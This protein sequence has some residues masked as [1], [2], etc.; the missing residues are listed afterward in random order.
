MDTYKSNL[1]SLKNISLNA[2]QNEAYKQLGYRYH[3]S[4][5]AQLDRGTALLSDTRTMWQYMATY[6]PMHQVKLLKAFKYVPP[7]FFKKPF[8]IVDWG[9]GQAIGTITLFDYL[10]SQGIPNLIKKVT[11]IDPSE[12][13]LELAKFHTSLYVEE[14]IPIET[15]ASFFEA[16]NPSDITPQDQ[17]ATLHI[18][19]N[20]IDI[21]EI[22]LKKLANLLDQSTKLES[23]V[24]CVSPLTPTNNRLHHF[25]RYFNRPLIHAESI[26][27]LPYKKLSGNP[28]ICTYL[29]IIFNL[30]GDTTENLYPIY[31]YP[32]VYFS[33]AASLGFW[34]ESGLGYFDLSEF[35]NYKV[36]SPFDIGAHAYDD[37]HPIL[38]VLNN[39][40]MRGLPTKTS[41]YIEEILSSAF[42]ATVKDIVR[43]SIYYKLNPNLSK[44]LIDN[45]S[46]DLFIEVLDK[47][48][49]NDYNDYQLIWL[50]LFLT[51][52][53]INRFQKVL[54]ESIIT[55]RLDLN[56]SEWHIL[57][58]EQDV[59][60]AAL[61]VNDF[62]EM[63]NNLTS[64]TLDY[65]DLNLPAIYLDIISNETFANSPLHIDYEVNAHPAQKHSIREYDMVYDGSML[66]DFKVDRHTFSKYKAKSDCYFK[67][68]S[69]KEQAKN[70]LIYTSDIIKYKSF[71][72]KN[73]RG[74]YNIN[75][76]LKVKLQYFL[77]LL[78]RKD[79][80]REGQLPILDR[81]M[82]FKPVIGLLPTGGGK[83]LTY[84][85]AAM[86]Q[87][88]VSIVIDPLKSLMKDQYEGLLQ[89]G[90]DTANFI[91]SSQSSEERKSVENRL[92][93]SELQI[94]FI[95]PERLAIESFRQSLR[96][97]HS[98]NV[99]FAYGVIDE[100]HCVSEWGHDFRFNYLHL[101]RNLYNYVKSKQ[102]SLCL[103]GLTAT[104]SFDV[105]A[106]VERE[107]SGKGAFQLD[108]D[109]VIRFE[110]TNRLELQYKIEEV[111][112]K[113]PED[114]YFDRNKNL[115]LHLPRP[116]NVSDKWHV[117]NVKGEYVKLLIK[118]VPLLFKDLNN[119]IAIK[120]I[121]DKF[122]ARIGDKHQ[123]TRDLS[124][125]VSNKLLASR[126]TYDAAGIVFCP[127]VTGTGI[128][129]SEIKRKLITVNPDVGS[130]TGRDSDES[131]FKNMDKFRGNKQAIM[132]ATK[133]FG[134]GIDKP[135]VRFTI[136]TNYSSS[137]EGFIQEAGR[138]GRDQ[139]MAIAFLLYANYKI[140]RIKPDFQ[141][142]QYPLMLIKNKWFQGDD[143]KKYIREYRLKIPSD[144]IE[145]VTPEHDMVKLKCN[146]NNRMFA[147]NNC[148]ETCKAY[149]NCKLKNTP[150]DLKG[151]H[152]ELD[153]KRKLKEIGLN[154]LSKDFTYMSPDFDTVLYFFDENFKGDAYELSNLE[155]L[156]FKSKLTIRFVQDKRIVES[157]E[158]N[159]F[160]QALLSDS[161]PD[162]IHVIVPYTEE[163]Y[164]DIAKAIYRM[165]CI[166][167]VSDFTQDY[168]NKTLKIQANKKAHGSYYDE[169]KHFLLRYYSDEKANEEVN[170]AKQQNTS[171]HNNP[172]VREIYNCLSY[173]TFF[174]YSKISE[175]RKRAILDM[176]TFCLNGIE[177]G[178]HW[179]Q[180]NEELKDYL[181]Y[182]FNS[183]YARS[184]Y[185]TEVGGLP[186]SLVDDTDYGKKSSIALIKK[187]LRVAN[188][189]AIIG[190]STP[191]DN[192]R[193]LQGASKYLLRSVTDTN[194]TVSLLW[195]FSTIFLGT[196][197]NTRLLNE[198]RSTLYDGMIALGNDTG[199]NDSFWEFFTYFTNVIDTYSHKHSSDLIR[200]L[201]VVVHGEI[202]SS[203]TKKYCINGK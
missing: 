99:Y 149:H 180:T 131:S 22:D 54:L 203:I 27:E 51:P 89:V 93:S 49:I 23:I 157:K 167:L 107:L 101:G 166:D 120:F 106:D 170:Y 122:A 142:N 102:G 32:P 83:S 42:N 30:D 133:A 184:G 135:N 125:E 188:D 52:L 126:K 147:F 197:D 139:R 185:K 137:L 195:A 176:R 198:L 16:L 73:D 88:G 91:N 97:M 183:K 193:H 164:P 171:S 17:S 53:A 94:L 100:V 92:K 152:M 5:Y 87:P 84:Q 76:E 155:Y 114:Q 154:E 186:F 151:W 66:S 40:I 199:F 50:Q 103:M 145:T 141:S 60:F 70:R 162:E 34:G 140:S 36:A 71:A 90:I 124:I 39:I 189:P 121:K 144:Y 156:L 116:V 117:F 192:V 175:K 64:L 169:L 177:K 150:R 18:L 43:G 46:Q 47:T 115:P 105:L 123:S 113:F 67:V 143:L 28:N 82:Q 191:V 13:I 202:L 201:R 65:H 72:S 57:V 112:I 96:H 81:A 9:C 178:K 21:V 2:I 79:D 109:T 68:G 196:K 61:A 172:T 173:L 85:L 165:A 118:K 55:G 129:V 38:A 187:Y 111:P 26:K 11:L 20:I 136:N 56:Q 8:E 130:Y 59:P 58:E 25:F 35:Y 108:S 4:L 163:N 29:S 10:N 182:Y 194:P 161:T 146:I 6:G 98:Y 45:F 75:E 3:S 128:S 1:L 159:G 48:I 14:S 63:F 86:L 77:K 95:S 62:T 158:S 15:H 7:A 104:A 119:D 80:F 33:S 44:D 31:Y 148:N 127:H 110:N 181:Y 138:A 174:V 19:S 37:V 78:F 200:E 74:V 168:R 179:L 153:L 24:V 134:M 41:I 12:E 132:V 190:F 160:M 69:T